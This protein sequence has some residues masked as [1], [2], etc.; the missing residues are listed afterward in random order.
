VK[1]PD[2]IL[3][4][5]RRK[6]ALGVALGLALHVSVAAASIDR[7]GR[8]CA[9]G[10]KDACAQLISLART[11]SAA[12]VRRMAAERLIKA[13]SRECPSAAA[14]RPNWHDGQRVRIQSEYFF[15]HELTAARQAGIVQAGD[16]FAASGLR[17]L[18][19][20]TTGERDSAQAVVEMTVFGAPRA[21][22][23]GELPLDGSQAAP[24]DSV[25]VM[26]YSEVAW[27][28]A[29][30]V[31]IG[32]RCVCSEILQEQAPRRDT[33]YG[34][35]RRNASEAPFRK[36][37]ESSLAPI[38]IRLG[39]DLYG[40]AAISRIARTAGPLKLRERAVAQLRDQDALAEIAKNESDEQLRRAVVRKLTD[41]AAL[42]EVAR[43]DPNRNVRLSAV[44]KLADPVVLSAIAGS[45]KDPEVRQQAR[46]RQ[47]KLEKPR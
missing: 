17:S 36:D 7:M 32:G 14:D 33:L 22:L 29:V 12:S 46:S 13:R 8:D 43:N 20:D 31:R 16:Q 9:A 27:K 11:S 26:L 19:L 34:P 38:M 35:P 23:Y 45:D 1:I 5:F 4:G 18:G 24:D 47:A 44:Q 6:L 28:G 39:E 3:R 40:A 37:L 42:A 30:T 25:A 41:Q 2:H 15:E 21:W 10:K